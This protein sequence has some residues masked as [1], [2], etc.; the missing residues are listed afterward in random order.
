MF[1]NVPRKI[2]GGAAYRP[3]L[4]MLDDVFMTSG[5]LAGRWRLSDDHLSNVRRAGKGPDWVKLPT[6]AVRYR[7]ADVIASELAGTGGPL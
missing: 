6:G 1:P 5:E 4:E 7:A 2:L 3:L